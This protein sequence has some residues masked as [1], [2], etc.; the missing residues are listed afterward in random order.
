MTIIKVF[1]HDG[2]VEGKVE[3]K[4]EEKTKV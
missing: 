3:N 1:K 4:V 2:V